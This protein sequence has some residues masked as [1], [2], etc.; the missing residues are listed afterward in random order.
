MVI[1]SAALR[2]VPDQLCT[3]RVSWSVP[4]LHPQGQLVLT[5]PASSGSAVPDQPSTWP[6]GQLVRADQPRGKPP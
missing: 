2:V 4:A 6:Q 5:N 3:H 1:W